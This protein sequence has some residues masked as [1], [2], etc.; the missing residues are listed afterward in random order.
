MT[1]LS[2]YTRTDEHQRNINHD[3]K[4]HNLITIY[5]LA[6]THKIDWE[7]IEFLR[8]ENNWKKRTIAEMYYIKKTR[9]ICHK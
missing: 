8:T 1:T 7:N 9:F 4:N 2:T 5:I 6:N 3:L